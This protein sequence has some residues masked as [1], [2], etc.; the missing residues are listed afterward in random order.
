MPDA[1]I[2]RGQADPLAPL[3]FP[4]SAGI[5]LSNGQRLFSIFERAGRRIMLVAHPVRT[6]NMAAVALAAWPHEREPLSGDLLDELIDPRNATIL[7]DA[8][9]LLRS[10]SL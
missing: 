10:G 4:I 7:R 8:L 5:Q 2:L 3:G 9:Q 1:T 6:G